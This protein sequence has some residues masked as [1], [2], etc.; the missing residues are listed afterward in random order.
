VTAT[1]S[2]GSD[3]LR[4]QAASRSM[5][6]PP[7]FK[8][9]LFNQETMDVF[10]TAIL[11]PA[12]KITINSLPAGKIMGQT[13]PAAAGLYDIQNSV[14]HFFYSYCREAAALTGRFNN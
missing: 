10:P 3:A 8:P 1:T 13:A 7:G 12:V 6:F 14:Y 4:F 9:Y 2:R 11:A 5:G